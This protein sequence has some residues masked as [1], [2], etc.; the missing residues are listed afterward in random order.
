MKQ[1]VLLQNGLALEAE[2]IKEYS[3]NVKV[4]YLQDRILI[5]KY[6]KESSSIDLLPIIEQTT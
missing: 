1:T 4:F 5:T 2:L 6:N 3:D